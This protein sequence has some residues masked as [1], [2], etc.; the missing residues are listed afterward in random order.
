MNQENYIYYDWYPNRNVYLNRNNMDT[1]QLFNPKERFEKGN[2][3][4][5]LYREYKN[6]KPTS[7]RANTDEERLSLNLQALCFAAHELNLYLDLHPEDQS[8]IALFNDYQ[9]Q[10]QDLTREYETKYGP[11][12]VS[13]NNNNSSFEWVNNKWPWEGKNV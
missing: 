6:Y 9:K 1:Q 2:L 3:F 7:L 10:I 8:M 11:L 5:N 4:S 12:F 13:S